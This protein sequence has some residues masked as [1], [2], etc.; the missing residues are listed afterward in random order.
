MTQERRIHFAAE[1]SVI[2]ADECF[3]FVW[4]ELL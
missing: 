2:P 4:F 3:K 1:F